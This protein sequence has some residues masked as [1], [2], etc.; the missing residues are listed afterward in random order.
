MMWFMELIKM[1]SSVPFI[2][3]HVISA[4]SFPKALS[5]KE[6]KKYLELMKNGDK[7]AKNKLI[8]HNLRLVAHISKKYYFNKCDPNDIIS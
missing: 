1:I 8:N 3:L 4:N 7:E 2:I 6:E 5:A